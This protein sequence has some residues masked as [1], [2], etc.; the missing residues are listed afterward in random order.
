MS[1]A[2]KP[3]PQ[4]FG[5]RLDHAD[6]RMRRPEPY[7]VASG[8]A[9]LY[10][11]HSPPEGSRPVGQA[12]RPRPHGRQ[13]LLMQRGKVPSSSGSYTLGWI[14]SSWVE[15]SPNRLMCSVRYGEMCARF[16]G[17]I[18]HPSSSNCPTISAVSRALWEI[19]AFVSRA[20]K[21]VALSCSMG[22]CRR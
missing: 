13:I 21:F 17:S 15:Y 10:G 4:V 12:A 6:G 19:T 3:A 11:Q 7:E 20:L 1:T 9:R 18:S 2:T 8:A 5:V 22:R 14:P 16:F